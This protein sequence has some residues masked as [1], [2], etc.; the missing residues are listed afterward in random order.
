MMTIRPSL[1]PHQPTFSGVY[2]AQ[3]VYP[4]GT[5]YHKISTG[6][7]MA[8]E[9]EQKLAGKF[10]DKKHVF[11]PTHIH[12]PRLMNGKATLFY[13]DANSGNKTISNA[14]I[15]IAVDDEKG[16]H[17]T[18]VEQKLASFDTKQ[19]EIEAQ[20]SRD[21]ILGSLLGFAGPAGT[22]QILTRKGRK[23]LEALFQEKAQYLGSLHQQAHQLREN[24]VLLKAG[25][26]EFE[27]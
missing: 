1:K 11:L 13:H 4:I 12:D 14:M 19:A 18:E 17:A 24:R 26:L 27:S 5:N 9:V 6:G 22:V 15:T 2:G 25:P 10:A 3:A 20:N 7:H 23:L 8:R 21:S 16:E